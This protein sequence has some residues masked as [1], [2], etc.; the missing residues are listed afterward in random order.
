MDAPKRL[1]PTSKNVHKIILDNHKV[2]LILIAE[3]IKVSKEHVGH[4]M[5]KYLVDETWLHH[6][7]PESK[8]SSSEWTACGEPTPKHAKVQQRAGKLTLD[9]VWMKGM[10]IVTPLH[11]G[12]K[13][14][15]L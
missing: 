10:S 3:A 9:I 1:L 13:V 6:F 8:R 14:K 12:Q 4:I 15:D 5:H 11:N 2:K 7:P